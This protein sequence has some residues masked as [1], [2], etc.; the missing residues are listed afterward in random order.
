MEKGFTGFGI[1][2]WTVNIGGLNLEAWVLS[3]GI[4]NRLINLG[5][6]N[7]IRKRFDLCW[8]YFG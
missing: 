6:N 8:L 7:Q 4:R 1:G 2:S 3:V 5:T